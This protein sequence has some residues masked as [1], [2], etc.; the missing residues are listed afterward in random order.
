MAA[1]ANAATISQTLQISTSPVFTLD[2]F[3][4]FLFIYFGIKSPLLI[5]KS[6]LISAI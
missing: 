2:R 4:D 1:G 3:L 6:T 5:L